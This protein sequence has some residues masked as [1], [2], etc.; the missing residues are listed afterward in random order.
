MFPSLFTERMPIAIVRVYNNFY[1]YCECKRDLNS[2]RFRNSCV[3]VDWKLK[4]VVEAIQERNMDACEAVEKE[5]SRVVSKFA[6]AHDQTNRV[7]GDVIKNFDDLRSSIGE[8]N[9]RTST[10]YSVFT[11]FVL[12]LSDELLLLFVCV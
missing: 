5:L 6:G 2:V 4:I 7:L 3:L 9:C 11:S 1:I 12:L 10:Y 8:G